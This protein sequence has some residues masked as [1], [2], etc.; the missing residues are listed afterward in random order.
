VSGPAVR[1]TVTAAGSGSSNYALHSMSPIVEGN[2][3]LL[4]TATVNSSQPPMRPIAGVTFQDPATTTSSD[5][6]SIKILLSGDTVNY[7]ITD[8]LDIGP[9]GHP[10]KRMIGAA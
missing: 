8:A 7:G 9:A 10:R 5:A 6:S 2:N 1:S 4:V 3:N